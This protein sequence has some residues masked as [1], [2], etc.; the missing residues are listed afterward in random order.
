MEQFIPDTFFKEEE[1]CGHIVTAKTK[2]LWATQLGCL[3]ELKRICE[4][5]NISFFASGGTL[6]GAV[7]HKGFIPWD[8]DLD[9]M[10]P[11]ED[12]VRFCE[13]APRE[14]PQP[15][16]FQNYQTEPGFGPAMSRIRNSETTGCTSYDL[17]MADGHYN[18]G[19]FIDIFPL[20]G[21]ESG[22]WGFLKQK[23]LINFW[24]RTIAGYEIKRMAHQ[25]GWKWTVKK[26]FHPNAL[27]W[28]FIGLFTDHVSVSKKLMKACSSAKNYEQ[29]GILSFGNFA[30]RFIWNKEWFDELIVL[31]FEFTDIA[32]PK[33]YDPI[34]Q[35]QYGNYMEF[36]KG[37]QFHTMVL[38][39]PDTP[40]KE[41]LSDKFIYKEK[42]HT[43]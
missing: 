42:S 14:L 35:T 24:K 13:V 41:K 8:D 3:Q 18:C 10:M 33:A 1:L 11:Y 36:V 16:F 9:V 27:L 4:K 30:K 17:S 22:R 34:L 31:P 37:S 2:K 21:I 25:G 28:D 12:Y 20:F 6:I 40:F 39:D 7:R 5:H 26:Y 29:V 38:C 15:Y 43:K 23:F 19:I 32:C